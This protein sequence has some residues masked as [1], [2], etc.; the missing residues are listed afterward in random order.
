MKVINITGKKEGKNKVCTVGNFDGFHKGHL[1]ILRKVKEESEKNNLD[2]AVITFEPH[3]REILKGEN[4]CKITSFDTKVEFLKNIGIDFLI[5]ISFDKEFSKL[6]KEDFLSFLKNNIKCKKLITGEDWR[7][8]KNREGNFKFAVEYGK[9]M[10]LEVE[11][12]KIEET[13]GKKI[14]SSDLRKLLKEGKVEKIKELLGRFYCITGNVVEGNKL[15]TKIGFPTINLKVEETL[16]LRTGVYIGLIEIEGKKY[17]AIMN[18]GKRPTVG[19]NEKLL[20]IHIIEEWN[21]LSITSKPKV[22]FLKF[23]RDEKQFNNIDELKNQI[24]KD[25]LYAKKYFEEVKN[26]TVI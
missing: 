8:G 19:G 4:V 17:K 16:C 23:V 24:K 1:K 15:G 21:N 20:E 13:E 26:E 5:L 9:K 6:S 7:F 14:S 3:P 2:S 12:V 10:G 11:K 18:Y 25:I 22:Y